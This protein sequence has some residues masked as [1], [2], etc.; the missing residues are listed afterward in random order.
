[1]PNDCWNYITIASHD[2]PKQLHDLIENE[3]ANSKI[4]LG[5][6]RFN[7]SIFLWS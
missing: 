5:F 6:E 3:F 1:M 2:N 7:K 4:D